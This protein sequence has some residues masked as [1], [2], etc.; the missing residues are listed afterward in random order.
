MNESSSITKSGADQAVKDE[1]TKGYL[2]S[3]KAVEGG[4][5]QFE[6]KTGGYSMLFPADAVISE[7]FANEKKENYF[8]AIMYSGTIEKGEVN[9]QVIYEDLPITKDIEANLDL[10]STSVSYDGEYKESKVHANTI[11]LGEKTT[12]QDGFINFN[13]F[14]F[15]KSNKGNQAVRFMYS[16]TCHREDQA[17]ISN[18]ELQKKIA[19]KL[20]YSV[21]FH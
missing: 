13:D 5:Y 3:A 9:T 15:I 18:K 1:Y 2:S 6:S 16:S 14:A 21:K 11:Y 4:F 8:E 17:C 19:H 12:E 7:H 20:I 10:L